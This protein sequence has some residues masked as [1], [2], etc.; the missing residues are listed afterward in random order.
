MLLFVQM[1]VT[2]HTLVI[3]SLY[4]DWML[5]VMESPRTGG[6]RGLVFSRIYSR[7]G[8]HVISCSQEGLIR[9]KISR[10]SL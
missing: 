8:R 7:D 5:H 6:N 3:E 10:A 9:T 2:L 1:V 4:L